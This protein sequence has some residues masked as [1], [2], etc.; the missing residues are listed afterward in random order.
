MNSSDIY[1]RVFENAS[2]GLVL[3]EETTGRVA[4]TNRAFLRMTGR[5]CAEVVGRGFWE[6]P[7]IADAAAGAAAYDRLR[8]AGLVEAELPLETAEGRWLVLK[9]N[10]SLLMPGMV[11]LEVLDVT[12][13]ERERLAAR[14]DALRMLAGGAAGEF[15]DLHRALQTSGELLLSSAGS[16]PPVA[17]QLEEIRQASDRAGVIAEQLLAFSGR[18]ACAHRPLELNELVESLTPRLRQLCGPDI[19]IVRDLS[20]DLEPVMADP[21]QVRQ[22]VLALAANSREAMAHGGIFR[23]ETRNTSGVEPGLGGV[24]GGG[25]YGMLV[26]S[27]NG[28]GLDDE[29]WAHLYVP[30]FSTKTNGKRRGLGLAAVHGMV[31]QAG[32]HLWA[33]SQPGE[34]ATFRVYLPRAE[35]NCTGAPMAREARTSSTARIL[36]VEANNG[37]RMLV[38]NILRRKNYRVVVARHAE[39]ALAVAEAEGPPDLLISGPDANLAQC[40]ARSQPSLRVLYL[41]G[42]TD[43]PGAQAQ[44]LP[45]RAA[46]LRKPFELKIL[47]EKIRQLLEP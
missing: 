11:Q 10:G 31:C 25:P 20:P 8:A 3:L 43:E 38:A 13:Q 21:G 36:L 23:L 42:Y 46:V 47:L 26:A 19:E 32:G 27:D 15:G 7:L 29:S 40:L 30:F 12:G 34:G 5:S 39:E 17:R 1:A 16:A 24:A 18:L 44:L 37:L 4:E 35:A 22:I 14:L 9:V 6:P 41:G 2:C 28:P 45:P 33:C